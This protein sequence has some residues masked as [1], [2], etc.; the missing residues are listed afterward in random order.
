MGDTASAAAAVEA[1][2]AAEATAVA[3]MDEG[4]E[5]RV[6]GAPVTEVEELELLRGVQVC[7]DANL[8][9]LYLQDGENSRTIL[10]GTVLPTVQGHVF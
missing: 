8:P 3:D 2:V 1:A 10:A 7:Y 9:A 6:R 5:A 4:A